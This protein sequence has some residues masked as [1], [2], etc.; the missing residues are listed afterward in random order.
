VGSMMPKV[1]SAGLKA[2]NMQCFFTAG[3]DEVWS[4]CPPA[5]P[6]ACRLSRVRPQTSFP[7]P[8]ARSLARSLAL[9]LSLV[10]SLAPSPTLSPTDPVPRG[11]LTLCPAPTD[12]VPALALSVSVW[13]YARSGP[14][15]LWPVVS[16]YVCR[17]THTHTHTHS[18]SLSLSHSLAL[19]LCVTTI[20]GAHALCLSSWR[21]LYMH[22]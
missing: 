1:V 12:P 9:L 22:V 3:A 17:H 15:P 10:R 8:L 5:L 2:L 16:V 21:A 18:L 14:C 4:R 20:G 19:S 11:L 6:A 7:P 13:M